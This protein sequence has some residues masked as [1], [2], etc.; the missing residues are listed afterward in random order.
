MDLAR[1]PSGAPALAV[2]LRE[3]PKAFADVVALAKAVFA[4]VA[5]VAMF[6][7][8]AAP[9]PPMFSSALFVSFA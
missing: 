7:R 4:V 1:V 5:E 8:P 6:C 9:P 2:V 3:L